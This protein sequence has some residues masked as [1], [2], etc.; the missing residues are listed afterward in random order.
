MLE[1]K[2]DAIILDVMLPSADGYEALQTL[3]SDPITASIP[4]VVCTVLKQ[5]DL[6]LALGATDFLAKPATQ[7]ALLAA[8]ARC[9]VSPH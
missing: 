8:L 3:R 5:R 4:V 2:P 7:G 1:E 6:A 9:W